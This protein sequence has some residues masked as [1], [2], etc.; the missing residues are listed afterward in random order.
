[1]DKEIKWS[2]KAGYLKTPEQAEMIKNEAFEKGYQSALND[3]VAGCMANSG[4]YNSTQTM[5]FITIYKKALYTALA[6]TKGVYRLGESEVITAR[7][8]NQITNEAD[9]IFGQTIKETKEG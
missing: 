9:Q 6:E 5:E 7:L 4:V 1:M 3:A 8:F 2:N